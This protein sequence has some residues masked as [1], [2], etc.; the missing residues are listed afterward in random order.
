LR[1]LLAE[2]EAL[3]RHLVT[4]L[5]EGWGYQVE[6]AS[7][8]L[9]ALDL[10]HAPAAARLAILDWMMPGRDGI[11]VCR[12]VR[13]SGNADYTYV[14]LLTA[15]REKEDVVTGLDAGADDYITKPFD[16]AELRSRVRSGERILALKGAL[17]E[18]V[19]Q[20]EEAL[21][22]VQRLQGLLP[23]CMHCKKIRDDQ[24][25]WH[26]METYI[27]EHSDAMFSHALC[28]E[29]LS[30][31][32]GPAGKEDPDHEASEPEPGEGST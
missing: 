1:I 29:C 11:E 6:V 3:T 14:I 25:T 30:K 18:K 26:R 19:D 15:K 31:Y 32:Y 24:H 20:L 17:A 13:A 16:E 4:R 5:L 22:H 23:I 27:E 28:D 12:Q 2:D 7:D 9:E 8:G 10:L 21:D